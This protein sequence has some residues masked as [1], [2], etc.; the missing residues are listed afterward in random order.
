MNKL[1]SFDI[2]N[3]WICQIQDGSVT[4]VFGDLQIEQG[5]IT[6]IREKRFTLPPQTNRSTR[7]EAGGRMLTVPMVNFHDHFYSRLAKG[8]PGQGPLN[9]FQNILKNLWWKLD[10]TLDRDMVRASAQMAVMESIRCGTTYIFDHHA[11]PFFVEGSLGTIAH[12]LKENHLRGVLCF[13][14]SDRNGADVT[15][16]SFYENESFSLKH[17]NADIRAMLGLH[18][19]FTLKDSSLQEAARLLQKNDLGIHIHL[20]E[21]PTD[22]VLSEQTFHASPLKRLTDHHLLNRKSILAHGIHLNPD[23][24]RTIAAS[25]SAIAFNPD[26]NMNN[27]V[28]LP[29]YERI[30]RQIPILLGTDGMHAN[31]VRTFKQ[32]FLLLRLKGFSFERAFEFIQK[33]FADQLTFV[34]Q[35]F[36]DFPALQTGN[37]ADLVLWDYIPPTPLHADNF[38]GHFIYG[39]SERQAHSVFMNGQPILQNFKFGQLR[40][41]EIYGA[42][43]QQ[44]QRIYDSFG[45]DQKA[46]IYKNPK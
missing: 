8:L 30:P 16:R 42:I 43:R 20:C 2:T 11:S 17:T 27:A 40:E 26:S 18:A 41:S 15:G 10:K 44:G 28:G 19:S 29:V 1:Q 3:A 32:L 35:Y 34:R 6:A 23:E 21:D 31:M 22:R 4:P 33:V 13:E 5:K 39:L 9:N 24:Y 38:W 46:K 12:V 36:P 37:R 7:L 45:S 25:G 14:T